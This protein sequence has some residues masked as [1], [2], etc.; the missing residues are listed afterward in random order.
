MTESKHGHENNGSLKQWHERTR[1]LTKNIDYTIIMKTMPERRELRNKEI[2]SLELPGLTILCTR[3]SNS[4]Y[5]K[6]LAT[7]EARARIFNS[8]FYTLR[9][10]VTAL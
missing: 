10:V 1:D 9:T 4:W 2:Q 3:N 6:P 5:F 7:V 8:F